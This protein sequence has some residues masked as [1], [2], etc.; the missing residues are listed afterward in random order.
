MLDRVAGIVEAVRLRIEEELRQQLHELTTDHEQALL[1]VRRASEQEVQD[2]ERRWSAQLVESQT[3]A[4]RRIDE[5][6]T[7]ARSAFDTE[8]E[9]HRTAASTAVQ[10]VRRLVADLD[11]CAS[12]TDVLN[13][14]AAACAARPGGA[15]FVVQDGTFQPWR[16]PDGV[17][18]GL[19][20]GWEQL[21][22]SAVRERTVHRHDGSRAIPLTIDREVVAVIVSPD[23]D[24]ED[25]TPELMASAGAARLTALTA[26]RLLQA[27]RWTRGPGSAGTRQPTVTAAAASEKVDVDADEPGLAARRYARLLISEIKLYNETAVREGREH[28]DLA[29][30]LGSEITRA[31]EIYEARVPPA[32][33]ARADYFQEELVRTLANGDASLLA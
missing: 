19:P 15:L 9:T 32:V 21:V 28:R 6:V 13:H 2:A 12:L 26:S 27:E 10:T 1:D 11:R 7:A 3:E 4:Q 23:G 30:R 25:L 20:L 17:S 22:D 18:I 24:I 29:H 14:L 5:A 8:R 31:R 16:R 33:P